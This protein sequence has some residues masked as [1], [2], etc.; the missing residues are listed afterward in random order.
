MFCCKCNKLLIHTY[1]LKNFATKLYTYKYEVPSILDQYNV[2]TLSYQPKYSGEVLGNSAEIDFLV[3]YL[4]RW[5]K[6]VLQEVDCGEKVRKN[7]M[8]KF[9][10]VIYTSKEILV[11]KKDRYVLIY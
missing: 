1:L 5:K 4:T 2:W 8:Y 3:S 9:C 6:K 7:G 11:T 10:Y